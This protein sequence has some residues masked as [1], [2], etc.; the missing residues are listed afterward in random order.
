MTLVSKGILI[1]VIGLVFG[2]LFDTLKYGGF[3]L[4]MRGM[5]VLGIIV[6]IYGLIKKA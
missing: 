3:T 4:V 1:F 2:N 6:F 5:M